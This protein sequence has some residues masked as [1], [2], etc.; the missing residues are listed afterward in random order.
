MQSPQSNEELARQRAIE[1]ASEY[2]PIASEAI[3]PLVE[4]I[5]TFRVQAQSALAGDDVASRTDAV[6]H[7]ARS[8]L[9]V[10]VDHVKTL[11]AVMLE[12]GIIPAF[13]G[14]TLIRSALE[15]AGVALWL[16]GP[17]DSDLRVLRAIQLSRE[18]LNDSRRLAAT[19]QGTKYRGLA[20]DD[21]Y[22]QRFEQMRDSRPA[23][24]GKSL[25]APSIT[26]RLDAA[27]FFVTKHS[28]EQETLLTLWQRTSGLAHGRRHAIWQNS[29]ARPHSA[30]HV[31]FQ[32]M[33]RAD[34]VALTA[35]F[36]SSTRY[37]DD[38]VAL[39]ELR[40]STS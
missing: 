28:P 21:E 36:E 14:F 7:Q 18:S 33:V 26:D 39:L 37:L 29:E 15:C 8:L 11:S 5:Q 17:P 27:E 1:I 35:H 2:F 20:P 16:L 30:D 10:G 24:A 23:N 32:V 38:G 3:E 9:S 25:V 31:G 6:S 40:G 19:S 13:A 4:R 12:G 22:L 34:L